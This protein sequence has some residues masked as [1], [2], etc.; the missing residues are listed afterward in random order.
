MLIDEIATESKP[1]IGAQCVWTCVC[2]ISG[3]VKTD[4]S[5]TDSWTERRVRGVAGDRKGSNR[6]HP[7]QLRSGF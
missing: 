1:A 2:H 5:V 7:R 6:D 3:R 4:E